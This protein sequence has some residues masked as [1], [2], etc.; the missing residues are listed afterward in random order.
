MMGHSPAEL[1]L[2]HGQRSLLAL[3]VYSTCGTVIINIPNEVD[4]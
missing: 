1:A 3:V 2:R 4:I